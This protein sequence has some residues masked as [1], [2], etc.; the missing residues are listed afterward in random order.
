MFRLNFEDPARPPNIVTTNLQLELDDSLLLLGFFGEALVS[1]ARAHPR[2][3]F[4]IT[5]VGGLENKTFFATHVCIRND[6]NE[7]VGDV[8]RT[9]HYELALTNERVKYSLDRGTS[10]RTSKLDVALR[11]IKK[12]CGAA[13]AVEL[14]DRAE[15]DIYAGLRAR[16]N[17]FFVDHRDTMRK[18]TLTMEDYIIANIDLFYEE[19]PELKAQIDKQTLLD[20]HDHLRISN[21]ILAAPAPARLTVVLRDD[22]YVLQRAGLSVMVKTSDTLPEEVRMKV[23]MLK[24]ATNGQCIYNV[25]YR[26]SDVAML[27]VYSGPLE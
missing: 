21:S 10:R 8:W 12:Y 16:V 17:R 1:A 18:I 3:Q 24:L 9:S 22:K 23:G 26:H 11:L 7:K 4:Q 19:V 13:P 14:I 27:V 20:A 5:R 2:W 15:I 6:R 25:G